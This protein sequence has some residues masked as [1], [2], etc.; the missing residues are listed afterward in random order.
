MT[1]LLEALTVTAVTQA[2]IQAS[3]VAS[4]AEVQGTM[5]GFPVEALE[6]MEDIRAPPPAMVVILPVQAAGTVLT[7]QMLLVDQLAGKRRGNHFKDIHI[8]CNYA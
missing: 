4:L 2:Q 6:A 7:T 5:E 8:V 1:V 3:I